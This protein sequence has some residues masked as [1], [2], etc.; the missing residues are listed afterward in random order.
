MTDIAQIVKSNPAM[1]KSSTQY[2]SRLFAINCFKKG[3]V[4]RPCSKPTLREARSE[5]R[6]NRKDEQAA[7]IAQKQVCPERVGAYLLV[8][9]GWFLGENFFLEDD[10]S[11]LGNSVGVFN[12]ERLEQRLT[13][14]G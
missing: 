3:L 8:P 13:V 9:C 4:P 14:L 6:H 2:R 11:L 1:L 12:L 10:F 5:D 7:I